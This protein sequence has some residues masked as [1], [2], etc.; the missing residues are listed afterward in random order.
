MPLYHF[1]ITNLNVTDVSMSVVENEGS[2]DDDIL[3][4]SLAAQ[5]WAQ[6]VQ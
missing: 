5:P 1:I 4:Q 6:K 3:K 2:G